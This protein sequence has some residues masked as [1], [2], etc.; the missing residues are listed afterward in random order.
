MTQ[1]KVF[2]KDRVFVG[3]RFDFFI[4]SLSAKYYKTILCDFDKKHLLKFQILAIKFLSE[5]N[6]HLPTL[7]WLCQSLAAMPGQYKA[8]EFL[9]AF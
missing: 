3:P 7:S 1:N 6:M 9:C 4:R 5:N 8:D 2:T